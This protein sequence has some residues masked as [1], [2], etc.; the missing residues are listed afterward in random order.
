MLDHIQG[1]GGIL[2]VRHQRKAVS[3][4]FRHP[5]ELEKLPIHRL[6]FVAKNVEI[7][8]QPADSAQ[9]AVRPFQKVVIFL[10]ELAPEKTVLIIPPLHRRLGIGIRHD[11][12]RIRIPKGH[13]TVRDLLRKFLKLHR[14]LADLLILIPFLDVH[15]I[16]IEKLVE[17]RHIDAAPRNAVDDGHGIKIFELF[18]ISGIGAQNEVC[19][20]LSLLA[21]QDSVENALLLC[22]PLQFQIILPDETGIEEE[23]F[24]FLH[25]LQH[26]RHHHFR[27]FQ[28]RR[29]HGAHVLIRDIV[30]RQR[31]Q[32]CHHIWH[33]C[34]YRNLAEHTVLQKAI[35]FLHM[36]IKSYHHIGNDLFEQFPVLE[37]I[38][39]HQA[40]PDIS[41]DIEGIIE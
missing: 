23:R 27:L 4:R 37:F 35:L 40:L 38:H 7:A 28:I 12:D 5:V 36:M 33:S 30:P 19:R 22:Q 10:P 20:R 31:F 17:I 8:V 13:H 18:P 24:F 6:V 11:M 9:N 25:R 32:T 14:D 26:I 21:L 1:E 3:R 15:H 2:S 39:L 16:D 41:I 29:I 34:R